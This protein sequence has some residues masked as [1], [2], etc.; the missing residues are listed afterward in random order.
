MIG[1]YYLKLSTNTSD[2]PE[3]F[4]CQF[5]DEE[6]RGYF[7]QFGC[8]PYFMELFE[9]PWKNPIFVDIILD[10]E[11]K[12]YITDTGVKA[13]TLD[14]LRVTTSLAELKQRQIIN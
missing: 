13:P 14:Q 9:K 11:S 4:I 1:N 2:N 10:K 8:V 12:K 3:L 5:I 6:N 7:T